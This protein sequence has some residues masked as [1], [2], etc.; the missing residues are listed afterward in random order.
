M[1]LESDLTVWSGICEISGQQKK[2]KAK[3]LLSLP[4]D[5]GTLTRP[6][7][8]LAETHFWEFWWS[9]GSLAWENWSISLSHRRFC[10][11]ISRAET[12]ALLEDC[13]E[14]RGVWTYSTPPWTLPMLVRLLQPPRLSPVKTNDPFLLLQYFPTLCDHGL[15]RSPNTFIHIEWNLFLGTHF[16]KCWSLKYKKAIIWTE[17]RIYVNKREENTEN[18]EPK[19][20]TLYCPLVATVQ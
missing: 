12:D 16:K 6:A 10:G 13:S 15:F 1:S 17:E 9:Q 19:L 8:P 2:W 5:P 3:P 14:D 11:R 4:N 18:R 20:P 7:N